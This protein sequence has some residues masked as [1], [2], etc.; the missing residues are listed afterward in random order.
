MSPDPF[1]RNPQDRPVRPAARQRRC[2]RRRCLPRCETRWLDRPPAVLPEG[3]NHVRK[4]VGGSG[5]FD[6]PHFTERYLL[7]HRVT[8]TAS[9]FLLAR[10]SATFSLHGIGSSRS[11]PQPSSVPSSPHNPSY[12][13]AWASKKSS[14]ISSA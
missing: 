6:R 13:S 9:H 2:R 12:S 14:T 5:G 1:N 10:Q 7:L 11:Q 3:I 4:L 8:S